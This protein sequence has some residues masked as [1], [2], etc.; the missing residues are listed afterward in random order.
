MEKFCSTLDV[1][2]PP[3][4]LVDN[5]DELEA[6]LQSI[7]PLFFC[8]V[9]GDII[10]LMLVVVPCCC[11]DVAKDGLPIPG[12]LGAIAG[13]EELSVLKPSGVIDRLCN[14]GAASRVVV[15][16]G[17]GEI[18]GVDQE[19]VA[20]GDALLERPRLFDGR[21]GKMVDEDADVDALAQGSPPS[22]SVPPELPCCPPRTSASKSVPP[23]PF[24][25]SKPFAVLGPP[26]V[27]NSLRVVTVALFAPSSWSLRACST[28]TLPDID[29]MR[30]M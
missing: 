4:G 25:V 10:L 13:K 11:W 12:L 26:K 30:V 29:L 28:S 1:L 23:S 9:D 18:G 19:K 24:V 20:A 14:L 22:I 3:H 17:A 15:G 5:V 7:P 16:G 6:R 2:L 27:M 8:A 21:D